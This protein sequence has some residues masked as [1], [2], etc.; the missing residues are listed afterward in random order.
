MPV[1]VEGQTEFWHLAV[2]PGF[3][4]LAQ[5]YFTGALGFGCGGLGLRVEG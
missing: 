2:L 5:A 1:N 3:G 4:G